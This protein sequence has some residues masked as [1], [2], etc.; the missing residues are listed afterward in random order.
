MNIVGENAAIRGRY[1]PRIV[2]L[3]RG[4]SREAV[5]H[6]MGFKFVGVGVA[7]VRWLGGV[8]YVVWARAWLGGGVV[9]GLV[10]CIVRD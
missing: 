3:I 5:S 7:L 2:I 1:K 6:V 10:L 8:G 4:Y 9:L